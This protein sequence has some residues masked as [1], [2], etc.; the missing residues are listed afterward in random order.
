MGCVR[1]AMSIALA[2]SIDLVTVFEAPS[3]Y[4]WRECILGSR[5]FGGYITSYPIVDVGVPRIGFSSG[6]I[7]MSIGTRTCCISAPLPLATY[8]CQ[9]PLPLLDVGIRLHVTAVQ[10]PS[11]SRRRQRILR[12]HLQN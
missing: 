12:E 1:L 6:D 3:V 7:S 10:T 4:E 11:P 9:D 2:V 5:M 8:V